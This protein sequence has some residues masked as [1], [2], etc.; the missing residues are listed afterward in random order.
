MVISPLTFCWVELC[1]NYLFWFLDQN[2]GS[3]IMPFGHCRLA[4]DCA[5]LPA[6][7]HLLCLSFV[8]AL[9]MSKPCANFQE[10]SKT[11]LHIVF[12]GFIFF[13]GPA[14]F[15]AAGGGAYRPPILGR[16]FDNFCQRLPFWVRGAYGIASNQRADLA[17]LSV[18]AEQ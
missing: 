6:A 1:R 10:S 3:V 2:S 15:P 16:R 4:F 13:T 5:V 7:A 18:V 12:I 9:P 17:R 11:N 8:V 14:G